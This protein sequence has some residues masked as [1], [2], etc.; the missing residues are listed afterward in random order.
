MTMTSVESQ[1]E[2]EAEFRHEVQAWL[3]PQLPSATLPIDDETWEFSSHR[4]LRRA[5]GAMTLGDAAH[6]HRQI[7]ASLLANAHFAEV[8]S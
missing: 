3:A 2:R 6:Q 1:V 8:R 7:A 4:C 5:L